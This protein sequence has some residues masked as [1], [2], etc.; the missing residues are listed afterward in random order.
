M[1]IAPAKARRPLHSIIS[2]QN[3]VGEP[4]PAL[5]ALPV[6]ADNTQGRRKRLPNGARLYEPQQQ[7][8]GRAAKVSLRACWGS[9]AAAAHR[10][11]LRYSIVLTLP[12]GKAAFRLTKGPYLLAYWRMGEFVARL[13]FDIYMCRGKCVQ[14]GLKAGSVFTAGLFFLVNT[15][16]ATTA[17]ATTSPPADSAVPP[18]ILSGRQSAR[19]PGTY[20]AGVT[21]IMRMLDAKVDE[22]VILAYI[23]NSSMRYDPE[24]TELI[25]LKQHGASTT[26]LTA[27]LH[28]GDHWQSPAPA[29]P[30]TSSPQPV[31]PAYFYAPAMMPP[32]Q[33]VDDLAFDEEPSPDVS[34]GVG[35]GGGGFY[36]AALG[37]LY[38]P[39]R[40]YRG[41]WYAH[42]GD[43]CPIGA[44]CTSEGAR[45]RSPDILSANALLNLKNAHAGASALHSGG[46]KSSGHHGGR[47]H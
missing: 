16:P 39:Y 25:A 33:P 9:R 5:I 13:T 1:F 27:L 36:G 47:S 44:A 42:P 37:N 8:P 11:A 17:V 46:G 14:I 7:P 29:A 24:A 34:Y 21:E 4:Q 19:P 35:F 26:I 30:T 2:R 45:A 18:L 3:R 32:N 10:A 43:T 12:W 22:Q 38:R 40:Y 31:A 23:E 15:S 20:S 6:E 41:C 28:H